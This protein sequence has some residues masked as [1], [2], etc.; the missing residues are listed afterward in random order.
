MFNFT[1]IEQLTRTSFLTLLM[2]GTL[3]AQAGTAQTFKFSDFAFS[4]ASSSPTNEFHNK[5]FYQIQKT[6]VTPV[7]TTNKKG[8]TT[9]KNVT[10]TVPEDVKGV[11]AFQQFVLK[12]AT[13]I[14]LN[15]LNARKL[16][17]TKLKLKEDRKINIYFIDEGAGY[18]NQLKLV[19][20]NGSA[21]GTNKTGLVFYDGSKGTGANELAAGDYVTV[22]NDSNDSDVV[23]AGTILDFQLKANGYSNASGDVW[24]TDKTKNVDKLQHVI[25][26]EYEGFLVLAWEDLKNGGDKDYNDIVFAVDIGQASLDAIPNEPPA[27]QAPNA[28]DDTGTTSYG[29][30]VPIDV[31]ANDTDPEGQALTITNVSSLTGATVQV[32]NGKVQYTPASDFNIAGGSDSFSY[33]IKDSLGATSSATVTISVGAKPIPTTANLTC[34]SNNGGGNNADITITLSTGKT[35][36]IS[37]FDPSN[38][39]NGNQLDNKIN[40]AN[41]NLTPVEFAAA[42]AQ[43]QQLIYDF[44]TKGSSGGAGCTPPPNQA[45]MALDDTKPT[46]NNTP[47]IIDVLANDKDPEGQAL[48]ITSVS[49]TT[50]GSTTGGVV[51]KTTDGKVKYTPKSN[52][53][54]RAGITDTFTYTIKDPQGATATATVTVNVGEQAN[55]APKAEDDQVSTLKKTPVTINVLA[56]DSDPDGDPVTLQSVNSIIG[57]N[58]QI[59]NGEVVYTPKFTSNQAASESFTYTIKDADGATSSASVTVNV[60]ANKAP[61]AEDDNMS[62]AYGAPITVDVLAN[63]TDADDQ[64]IIITSANSKTGAKVEVIDGKVMYT[65]KADFNKAGGS[66]TFTYTIKD[67]QDATD[68]ATVTITVDKKPNG[69]PVAVDDEKPTPYGTSVTIDVM[70]NDSDPDGDS[71]SIKEAKSETGANVNVTSGQVVYTPKS[72]FDTAGGTD[73]FTYTIKDDKG[74]ESSATVTV[75]VGGKGTAPEEGEGKDPSNPTD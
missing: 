64:E 52:L 13:A 21:A 29:T 25:A 70:A 66:D 17:P 28:K 15:T 48:T 41:P 65:P 69:A 7:T 32:V 75:N 71:I 20:A 8:V 22:G 43:L 60:G 74:V 38:P 45:P 30:S 4:R 19:A 36:T 51:E 62:T 6:V 68:E 9:T 47:V 11:N 10:T 61:V 40:A 27:N 12:E 1:K 72:N 5:A 31:L 39:G 67:I 55:Q 58:V 59:V 3:L 57:A 44:E 56:N 49:S 73:T 54:K 2:A 63:D 34:K 50:G 14:D 18:R 53:N 26:Y 35:L 23:K 46:D 37:K 24:Y 42:K 16:D 33:I